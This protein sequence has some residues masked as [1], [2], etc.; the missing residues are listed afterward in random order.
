MA[1]V[2]VP[3]ALPP[4]LRAR[5]AARAKL[6][7]EPPVVSE[8]DQ[9]SHCRETVSKA[10]SSH[11][12]RTTGDEI[13]S[14]AMTRGIQIKSENMVPASVAKSVNGE[15]KSMAK[16]DDVWIKATITNPSTLPKA[17]DRSTHL[18]LDDLK[19][20][21]GTL[22]PATDNLDS[23]N[24]GGRA[25]RHP[26]RTRGTK[27][28]RESAWAR[29]K[30]IPKG[31]DGRWETD[32][33]CPHIYEPPTWKTDSNSV[34]GDDDYLQSNTWDL[35]LAPAPL[36]WDSR[37]GF[38]KGQSETYIT[39]WML[40]S[41]KAFGCSTPDF[42]VLIEE[43]EM[44]A[45]DIAPRYWMPN[46]YGKQAPQVF[47]NETIRSYPKPL[48]EDDFKSA[49]PWWERYETPVSLLLKPYPTPFVVGI[50]PDESINERLA[51]ENDNGSASH[52]QNRVQFE[53]AKRDATEAQRKKLRAK[54]RRLEKMTAE[55]QRHQQYDATNYPPLKPRMKLYIRSAKMDDMP[56]ICTIYN[57]YI[58]QTCSSAKISPLGI[59]QM[60]EKFHIIQAHKLPFI[61][62]CERGK[63]LRATNKRQKRREEEDIVLPDVVVGF[64]LADCYSEI[65][66]A[67]RYSVQAELYT[68]SSHYRKAVANCLMDKLMACLD[69]Q[70]LER[71]GYNVTDEK[72]AC[73]EPER[74]VQT[75][76]IKM[77]YDESAP[78][79][80]QWTSKWL[81]ERFGF[82]H[83]GDLA[84]V[85]V[86]LG[87]K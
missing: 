16:A 60:T 46:A 31:N 13:K 85:G 68:A 7:V 54:E 19:A 72:L 14:M 64:A 59:T 45:S 69:P 58:T 23:K 67:M 40:D 6:V 37:P 70:Y 66:D 50:D 47:W 77:S 43:V 41:D 62:A 17:H 2:L 27:N 87:K 39:K 38:R 32:W 35:L 20:R 53:R 12:P 25:K 9:N 79:R 51:R 84:A 44:A 42:T 28:K 57:F 63:I 81:M 18:K 76:M 75:I 56:A 10:S 78:L 21:F 33:N 83:V 22:K 24:T 1:E 3:S 52:A 86:K 74:V 34:V 11:E 36:N 5:A 55:Q 61:V 4:H 65:D 82:I 29:S 26:R 49:V 80:M 73:A 8:P 30:D 48:D 71:G 15:V